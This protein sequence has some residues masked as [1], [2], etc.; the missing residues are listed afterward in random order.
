MNRLIR[1]VLTEHAGLAVPIDG[2]ADDADL[3]QLGLTSHSTVSVLLALEDSLGVEFPI[4]LLRRSTFE[5]VNAISAALAEIGA[6]GAEA[7]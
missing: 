3:Y 1:S 7:D 5:S 2:I 4:G 6:V